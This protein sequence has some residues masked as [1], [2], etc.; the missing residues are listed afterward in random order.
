MEKQK[1]I[2]QMQGQVLEHKSLL[3]ATD[4]VVIRNQETGQPI[5]EDVL[6]ERA[7]ARL[8]ISELELQIQVLEDELAE[9]IKNQVEATPFQ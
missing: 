3:F 4:Y 2:N 5:P 8:Q 1:Q 9:E 6:Q 7:Q